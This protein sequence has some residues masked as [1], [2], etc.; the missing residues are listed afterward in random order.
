MSNTLRALLVL[1][2]ALVSP[3][4]FAQDSLNVTVLGRAD[5]YSSYSDIWGYTTQSGDE[6][7]CAG[8]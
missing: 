5:L 7:S 2:V 3:D 8:S 6:E 4:A 1:A